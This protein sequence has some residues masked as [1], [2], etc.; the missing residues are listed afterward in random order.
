[1]LIGGDREKQGIPGDDL[2]IMMMR[3]MM[4]MMMIERE[5]VLM[6]NSRDGGCVC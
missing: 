4:M 2:F 5:G 3:R 1:M 6:S